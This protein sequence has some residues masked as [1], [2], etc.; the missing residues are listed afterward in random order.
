MLFPDLQFFIFF[1]FSLNFL[2]DSVMLNSHPTDDSLPCHMAATNQG[3]QRLLRVF[4]WG[5][6]K[7]DD[8]IF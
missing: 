7:A 5:T 6:G 4:L 3:G 8:R 2:P 1:P